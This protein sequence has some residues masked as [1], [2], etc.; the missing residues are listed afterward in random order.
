MIG[1]EGTWYRSLNDVA[2]AGVS[3]LLLTTNGNGCAL[4]S[5]GDT[6]DGFISRPLASRIG[7]LPIAPSVFGAIAFWVDGRLGLRGW[8]FGKFGSGAPAM[9]GREGPTCGD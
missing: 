7:L 4:V 2:G 5:N 3:G 1:G 6:P 9:L 8:F